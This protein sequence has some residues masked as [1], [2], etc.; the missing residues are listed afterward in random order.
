V[1]AKQIWFA[2]PLTLK[3]DL[4]TQEFNTWLE[5]S[6]IQSSNQ[7]ASLISALCYHMWKARNLL[8]FQNKDVPVLEIIQQAEEA[9]REFQKLQQNPISK[10][11][12]TQNLSHNNDAWC[13]PPQ[14]CL[15]LNVDAHDLRDGHWG[16]GL[17]LRSED[18]KV[19]GARTKV[20]CSLD[21]AIEAEALGF[22]AATEFVELFRNHTIIIEMDNLSVVNAVNRRCFPR[23][24]WGQIARKGAEY[25][26]ANAHV[27]LQWVNRNRNKPAHLLAKWARL[28][29][30]KTW[31]DNMPSHIV[32]SIISG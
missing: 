2:S 12:S 17:L 24:Y 10:Q 1:W 7:N 18:G 11:H 31:T 3:L 13:P 32:N 30:N 21:D 20:V 14:N 19:V 22:E 27:T 15:K 6:I 5:E 9:L 23:R 8:V 25:L 28:E 4:Q 29:P 16:L 26:K